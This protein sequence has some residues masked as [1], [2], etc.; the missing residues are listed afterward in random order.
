MNLDKYGIVFEMIATFIMFISYI[1][2][3]IQSSINYNFKYY[4]TKE[5]II[6]RLFFEQFSYE[7][8]TN[9][10]QY[11]FSK[12]RDMYNNYNNYYSNSMNIELKTDSFYDCRGIYDKEL[13]EEICQNKII[14]NYTCCRAECC[15]RTNGNTVK[16]N[17]YQFD[18][19]TIPL[20]NKILLYNDDE[21]FEDPRRRFCTYYNN[22]N[23]NINH[24]YYLTNYVNLY[25]MKFNYYEL[26][27]NASNLMCIG[28]TTCN[29]FYSDCGIIDTIGNHLYIAN[30]YYCPITNIY[31]INDDQYNFYTSSSSKII[32]RNIISEIPPNIH[33]WSFYRNYN[34][35][36]KIS[37][38]KDINI[39]FNNNNYK[40]IYQVH[41]NNIKLNTNNGIKDYFYQSPIN[42]NQKLNWYTTT[43]IGFNNASDLETF[44]KHFGSSDPLYD[45]GT[46]LYPSTETIIIII[47]LISF[48]I[49]YTIL[50]LLSII[51]N[52][53]K[54]KKIIFPLFIVKQ[55]ILILSFGAA[56][57]VYI[58]ITHKFVNIEINMDKHYKVILD[59][60][61]KKR[62][63]ILFLIGLILLP[64]GEIFNILAWINSKR[65]AIRLERIYEN[66]LNS[67]SNNN[68]LNNEI[69]GNIN[70][71]SNNNHERRVLRFS[72]NRE[73]MENEK[74]NEILN[75][76]NNDN[77][78]LTLMQI[79][80]E[81]HF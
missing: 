73:L 65:N 18:S 78:R 72:E 48:C 36:E 33:D 64:I 23:G 41:V 9:I 61:N 24:Y 25:Q 69:N 38:I 50:F 56:L 27:L 46:N 31:N 14:T 40:E 47:V 49:V 70:N 12:N 43:Y 81:L 79:V 44:F 42:N 7:I 52:Y 66:P 67:N 8:N 17:N 10:H 26:F 45:M 54:L 58:W 34:T 19:S 11:A 55:I 28:K 32:I 39:A 37:N 59:L 22:Y 30:D 20:N 5:A 63:Q 76:N 29:E 21:F 35:K 80:K 1:L 3:L 75:K 15:M 71:T 60:Y 68:I 16:C 77:N 51:K 2:G 13:N 74:E 62:F 6:E 57:G 53:E 4:K